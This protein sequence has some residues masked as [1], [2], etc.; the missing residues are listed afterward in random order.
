MSVHE[1]CTE[2]PHYSEMD[3]AEATKH[4]SLCLFE[5][6]L[7]HLG[8]RR[9]VPARGAETYARANP[10]ASPSWGPPHWDRLQKCV[11]SLPF[12]RRT[13]DVRDSCE[14]CVAASETRVRSQTP[15]DLGT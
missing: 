3:A 11:S 14:L 12:K 13:R 7:D 15:V 4:S 5:C 1:S 9:G 6:L 8:T 2:S 10:S